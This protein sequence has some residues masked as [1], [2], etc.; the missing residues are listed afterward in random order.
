[1]YGHVFDA[2][3]DDVV[4]RLEASQQTSSA[5]FGHLESEHAMR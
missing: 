1:V 3:L 5:R 4:A 2:D